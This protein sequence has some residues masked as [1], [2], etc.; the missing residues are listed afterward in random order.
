MQL[1]VKYKK[2]AA[3]DP[4]QENLELDIN[5]GT[6]SNVFEHMGKCLKAD[7]EGVNYF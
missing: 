2:L 4:K 6:R 5:P 7:Q 1:Q 3:V